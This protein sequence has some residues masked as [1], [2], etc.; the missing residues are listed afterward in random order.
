[1]SSLQKDSKK[2]GTP[3]IL[4]VNKEIKYETTILIPVSITYNRYLP[5]I[6]NIITKN[7]NILQ[8]SPTIQKVFDKKPMITHKRNKNIGEPI[9]GHPLQGGKVFK[10]YLQIIKSESISC[11]ATNKSSLCCN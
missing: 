8:I 6:S 5:K 11:N 3:K 9:R 2:E 1:M 7:W 10:T 4:L